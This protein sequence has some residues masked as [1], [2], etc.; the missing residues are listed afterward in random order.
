MPS[1]NNNNFKNA[2]NILAV[3]Q[4]TLLTIAISLFLSTGAG[5]IYYLSSLTEQTL[6]WSAGIILAVSVFS[7]SLAAGKKAGNKGICYGLSVGVLFFFAVLLASG[8]LLP[9]QAVLG[10]L[11]KLV[12]SLA[13]GAAGGV[14]G[15]GFA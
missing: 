2:V 8:L 7:G 14:L 1:I 11:A 4:G 12:I 15:V 6:P 13:A 5:V 10:I 3:V 9:A